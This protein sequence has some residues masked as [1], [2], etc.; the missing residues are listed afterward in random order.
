MMA[1]E[2]PSF[3]SI[4]TKHLKPLIEKGFPSVI[5]ELK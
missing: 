1:A 3:I 4:L 5:N 2:N